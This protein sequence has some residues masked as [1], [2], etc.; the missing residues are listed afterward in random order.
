M[1]ARFEKTRGGI[2][3]LYTVSH[4]GEVSGGGE[5]LV[6]EINLERDEGC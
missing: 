4:R 5:V 3:A 2:V 6:A 1:T